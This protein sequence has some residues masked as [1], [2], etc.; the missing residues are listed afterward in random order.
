MKKIIKY[1]TENIRPPLFILFILF[2]TATAIGQV[3]QTGTTQPQTIICGSYP[4]NGKMVEGVAETYAGGDGCVTIITKGNSDTVFFTSP[5]RVVLKP[6]F[7]AQDG[8]KFIAYIDSSSAKPPA[9]YSITAS[10]EN[11]AATQ[12]AIQKANSNEMVSVA[13]NPFS[14]TFILS[15]NSDKNVKA[16][17]VIYNA[18]GVTVKQQGGINIS[19]GV[20]K[21]PLNCSGLASGVYTIEIILGNSKA[22]KK[23]VKS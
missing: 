4:A 3:H 22:M 20:N 10:N 11:N 8:S 2:I 1:I 15:V 21:I 18:V 14:S 9:S 23:I 19:K 7:I 13:P 16:Q 6:G 17:V 12:S 5:V